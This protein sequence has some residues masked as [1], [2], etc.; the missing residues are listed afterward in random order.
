M[1]LRIEV[2]PITS[3]LPRFSVADRCSSDVVENPTL[4]EHKETFDGGPSQLIFSCELFRVCIIYAV[5]KI[6]NLDET[7][8]AKTAHIEFGGQRFPV[9]SFNSD[10]QAAIRG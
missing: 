7:E 9:I 1:F 2:R 6:P 5:K 10:A 8:I 4:A 3:L